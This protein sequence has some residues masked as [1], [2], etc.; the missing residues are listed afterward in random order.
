MGAC[1]DGERRCDGASEA[2]E[3]EVLPAVEDCG[4]PGNESCDGDEHVCTGTPGWAF[5]YGGSGHEYLFGVTVDAAG[6]IVTAGAL[7]SSVELGGVVLEDPGFWQDALVMKLS[8]DGAVQ[9]ARSFGDGAPQAAGHVTTDA[10]RNIYV[11]GRC[12]TLGSEGPWTFGTSTI[13]CDQYEYGD[14]AFLAKLSPEGEPLWIQRLGNVF[15]GGGPLAMAPDGNLAVM[16]GRPALD[17]S[18][19]GKLD[20]NGAE[21]W[22]V[23]VPGF[24]TTV[25]VGLGGT[26]VVAG[27]TELDGMFVAVL[28]ASGQLISRF[29]LPGVDWLGQHLAVDPKGDLLLGARAG[30]D[31]VLASA[32]VPSGALFAA[33]LAPTGEERWVRIADSLDAEVHLRSLSVDALGNPVLA[34]Q[35]YGSLDFGLG[36]LT[37]VEG[38]AM[39]VKLRGESGDPLWQMTFGSGPEADAA[40]AVASDGAHTH[41]VV[42]GFTSYAVA[43]GDITLPNTTEEGWAWDGLVFQLSE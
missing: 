9:W 10:Q 14:D 42:G 13:E 15:D 2:C 18:E 30:A 20:P 38:D 1:R 34:G 35:W 32:I 41:Y 26:I 6:D 33:K 17:V 16:L 36:A 28:D 27:D 8:P 7:H 40:N 21:L 31:V 5:A 29:E 11:T 3:G 24:V 23:Q 39:L 12:G 25:A 43:I 4:I 22:R 37:S 19:V